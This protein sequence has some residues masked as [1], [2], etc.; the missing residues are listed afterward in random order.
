MRIV[1]SGADPLPRGAVAVERA[2]ENPVGGVSIGTVDRVRLKSL[3]GLSLGFVGPRAYLSVS[4]VLLTLL[5][6]SRASSAMSITLALYLGSVVAF[7]VLPLAGR[8]SDRTGSRLGR[9]SPYMGMGLLAMGVCTWLFTVVHGY[10]PLVALIVVC[11]QGTAVLGLTSL[12]AFSESFGRSRWIRAVVV[13]GV[14]GTLLSLSIKGVIVRTWRADDP[15][16]W[17]PP[18]RLAGVAMVLAGMAVLLLVREVP[19]ARGAREQGSSAWAVRNELRRIWSRRNDRVLLLGVLAFGAGTGATGYLAIVYFLRDL[20]AGAS[21]QTVAAVVTAVGAVVFGVPVGVLV[22]RVFT[23]RQIGIGAPL[24]GAATSGAVFYATHLWQAVVLGIAGTP[25][26]VAF[27]IATAAY[28][29]QLLPGSGGVGERLG[30]VAAP[31]SVAAMVVAFAAAWTVDLVGDYRVIWLFPA[32]A[33]V[34]QALLMCWFRAVPG[35]ERARLGAF[36]KRS[37]S[38][39][40][41]RSGGLASLVGGQVSGDDTDS[42]SL[43]DGLQRA[44]G[45]PY[46]QPSAR[47]EAVTS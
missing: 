33:G 10:W 4:G 30:L 20:H 1:R 6:A 22:S 23:R 8:A 7:V 11:Q 46:G 17:L 12:P 39:V 14:L 26:L 29:V 36:L 3:V 18:F 27:L 41:G 32:G 15:A 35:D 5:V 42:N 19:T 47:S 25:L 45:N 28:L 37:R 31:F 40:R 44:L 34:L 21:Q 2:V 43:L 9:R 38:L 16:S 13:S 24:V